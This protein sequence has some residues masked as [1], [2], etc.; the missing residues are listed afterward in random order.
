M[1]RKEFDENIILTME[2]Y[3]NAEQTAPVLQ[4]QTV[5]FSNLYSELF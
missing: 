3:K 5:K 4:N 1:E 2:D